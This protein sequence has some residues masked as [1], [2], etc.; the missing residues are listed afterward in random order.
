MAKVKL[1][2][3][4]DKIVVK[5]VE[6]DEKTKS[7]IIIPDTASKEKPQRGEVVAAG[8]G[9]FDVNGKRLPMD[10]KVG[11]QVLFSKYSPNEVKVDG[12]EYLIISQSDVL[13]V[14]K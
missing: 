1:Q 6:G 9:R 10:V 13:A 7:G 3:L 8:P 5:A 14:I 4:D 2:P 11:D 12:E